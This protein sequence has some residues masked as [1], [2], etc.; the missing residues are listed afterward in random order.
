MTYT[1]YTCIQ[2]ILTCTCKNEINVKCFEKPDIHCTVWMVVII[3]LLKEYYQC[4]VWLRVNLI[5]KPFYYKKVDNSTALFVYD[6][7]KW[8]HYD[9]LINR[10]WYQ[11]RD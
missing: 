5:T 7:I 11:S 10:M 1:V 9:S 4:T 6:D 2:N 8:K 3:V